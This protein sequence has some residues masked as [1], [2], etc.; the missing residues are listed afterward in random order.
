MCALDSRRSIFLALNDELRVRRSRAVDIHYILRTRA[1]YDD[2][3]S[4]RFEADIVV[5]LAFGRFE[6]D[7]A[8]VG[9]E[10]DVHEEV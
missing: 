7:F 9:V 5:F 8:C 3:V 6:G 2:N 1:H 4:F 10:G